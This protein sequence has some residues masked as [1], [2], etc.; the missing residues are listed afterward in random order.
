VSL[1]QSDGQIILLGV[2][3]EEE[4]EVCTHLFT[5]LK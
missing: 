1:L 4:E 5:R 2:K 3:E